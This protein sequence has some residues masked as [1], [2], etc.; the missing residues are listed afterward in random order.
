MEDS[1]PDRNGKLRAKGRQSNRVFSGS[2]LLP[3]TDGRSFWAR[4]MKETYRGLVVGHCGGEDVI[5]ETKRCRHADQRRWKPSWSIS[6]TSSHQCALKV[7]SLIQ[8][9]SICMA[10]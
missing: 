10:A 3:T 6:K 4:L 2:T 1:T 5:S 9:T 8:P 7:A